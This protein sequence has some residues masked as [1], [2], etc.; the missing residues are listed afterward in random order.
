MGNSSSISA[1]VAAQ[2]KFYQ[3]NAEQG[4]FLFIFVQKNK[5]QTN[6]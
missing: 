3:C 6:K 2:Q 5:N 1:A 4:M